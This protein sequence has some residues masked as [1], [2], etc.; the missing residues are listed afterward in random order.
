MIKVKLTRKEQKSPEEFLKDYY[1][2]IHHH[3][4]IM[5]SLRRNRLNDYTHTKKEI[6]KIARYL[7]K[8]PPVVGAGLGALLGNKISEGDNN[9]I[10][11]GVILGGAGGLWASD[12]IEHNLLI[13]GG[14]KKAIK[15]LLPSD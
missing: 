4:N 14:R 1:S 6:P 11:T 15:Y 13:I 5:T 3:Q 7:L 10:Q 9:F 12:L 2:E 8:L